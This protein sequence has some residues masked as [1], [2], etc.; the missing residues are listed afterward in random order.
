MFKIMEDQTTWKSALQTASGG[1][2]S[3][4]ME[5]ELSTAKVERL[6]RLLKMVTVRMY[7]S[8]TTQEI[9]R[10]RNSTSNMLTTPR[11]IESTQKVSSTKSSVSR[12]ESHSQSTPKWD[13]VKLSKSSVTKLLSR[14]RMV[15]RPRTGSSTITKGQSNH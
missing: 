15:K 5:K 3:N 10:T 12:L 2:S 6:L 11:L 8:N 9:P 14:E 13:V 1:R 7:S 4:T